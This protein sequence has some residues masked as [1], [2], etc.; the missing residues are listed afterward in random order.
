MN[1]MRHLQIPHSKMPKN[2]GKATMGTLKGVLIGCLDVLW[3][4][5]K[6]IWRIFIIGA[7]IA[8]IIG[9]AAYE[10]LSKGHLEFDNIMSLPII[11]LAG[12]HPIF[13]ACLMLI[14]S[15]TIITSFLAHKYRQRIPSSSSQNEYG[16]QHVSQLNPSNYKLFRYIQH[17]YIFREADSTVRKILQGIS[18]QNHQ[19]KILGICIF[20]KPAQG[21]T[22]LAWEAM[23]AELAN[24]TLVRWSHTAQVQF[25]F[26]AQQGKQIILWLDDLHEYTNPNESVIINDLPRRFMEEGASMM[27]PVNWT[28]R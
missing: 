12:A 25:D 16:L 24:W 6:S 19:N 13:T 20:G 3:N 5:I 17:A 22:R 23:Q 14:L 4:V 2:P 8:G 28:G 1:N 26:A 21:K 18:A 11:Q 7:I 10:Y 9:N 27:V 15:T